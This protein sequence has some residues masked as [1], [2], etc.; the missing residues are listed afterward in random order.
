[1]KRKRRKKRENISRERKKNSFFLFPSGPLH[2]EP[3][4]PLGRL[5]A[6]SLA[7]HLLAAAHLVRELVVGG[8]NRL[9][10]RGEGPE[11]ELVPAAVERGPAAGEVC[12]VFAAAVG[13]VAEGEGVGREALGAHGACGC[14]GGGG[15]DGKKRGRGRGRREEEEEKACVS[16]REE[17]E[18]EEEEE[19]KTTATKTFFFPNLSLPSYLLQE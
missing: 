8:A 13:V 5:V 18:V 15:G 19:K 4:H 3:R 2:R 6:P 10:R 14:G 12:A 1:M 16:E 17:Q 9:G 11:E 7:I